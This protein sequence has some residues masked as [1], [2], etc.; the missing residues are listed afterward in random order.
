M[1]KKLLVSVLLCF[2]IF[3]SFISLNAQWARTYGGVDADAAIFI[4]Q[5]SDGAYIVTGSTKSFGAGDLDF[6]MLKLDSTG[7]IEWQNTYGGPDR[8]DI[9][10][11]QQTN[12]E[13]YVVAGSTYNWGAGFSDIW[14]LKLSSTGSIE[15]QRT[16]GGSDDDYGWSIEKTSDGGY[17][18]AGET[19]SFGFSG[20]A[21]ILKLSSTGSIEWQRT[22]GGNEPD[23][24]NTFQK[25][26]EEG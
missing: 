15:W 5:T 17:I 24:H 7:E 20:N 8:D 25:T 9:N 3:S 26:R 18:V 14:I 4:H 13:G 2:F 21:W 16:Y 11:I 22:Y 10:S 6:W 19:F 23:Y 12:D 1:N